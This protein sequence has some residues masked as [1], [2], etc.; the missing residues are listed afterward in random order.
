TNDPTPTFSFSST[1][2]PATF[3]CKVDEGSFTACSSPHTTDPLSDGPHTFEVR[4]KD[5]AG[6]ID[7]TPA[8]RSFTVDTEE[9]PVPIPPLPG[10]APTPGIPSPPVF[11]P[12]G[13]PPRCTLSAKRRQTARKQI[14]VRV[15]C[16]EAVRAAL[17]GK[18]VVRRTRRTMRFRLRKVRAKLAAGRR[19]TLR[20]R[21][22]N[23]KA[24]RKLR[25]LVRRRWTARAV[26]R[27]RCV[28]GAGNSTTK[29]LTVKLTR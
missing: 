22:K 21:P 26:I 14:A 9:P 19:S 27:V 24:R 7:P 28:D 25:R 17:V 4:A 11:L 6:N 20:L 1:E 12:D 10:P 3:E 23:R 5:L 13:I 15:R 29:H 8:S 2:E 16:D 18:A